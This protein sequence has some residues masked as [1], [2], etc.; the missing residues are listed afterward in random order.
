MQ[1]LDLLTFPIELSLFQRDFTLNRIWNTQIHYPSY[2]IDQSTRS[3]MTVPKSHPPRN[4][5][6]A[7]IFITSPLHPVAQ[8]LAKRT[9][10]RVIEAGKDGKGLSRAECLLQ[11][12]A[13]RMSISHDL[14]R[15]TYNGFYSGSSEANVLQLSGKVVSQLLSSKWISRQDCRSS[16]AL[17]WGM[18][19]LILKELRKGGS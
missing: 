19:V 10:A 3:T 12:D 17:G 15:G 9:F 5:S 6:E 11:A 14:H 1:R 4:A 8:E 13:A 16:H 2:L 7:T 18:I